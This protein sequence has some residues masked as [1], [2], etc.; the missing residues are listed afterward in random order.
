[1]AALEFFNASILPIFPNANTAYNFQQPLIQGV[2][3]FFKLF[4]LFG[5]TFNLFWPGLYFLSMLI[6]ATIKILIRL[7]YFITNLP[8]VEKIIGGKDGG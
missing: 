1:M 8:I 3:V 6:T 7:F 2:Q 4:W 5:S